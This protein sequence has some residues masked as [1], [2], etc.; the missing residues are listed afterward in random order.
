MNKLADELAQH[1]GEVMIENGGP[2]HELWAIAY[3]EILADVVI[4]APNVSNDEEKIVDKIKEINPKIMLVITK[5]NSSGKYLPLDLVDRAL[6]AKAN[7]LIE[8]DQDETSILASIVDPLGNRFLNASPDIKAVANRLH[9]RV[10]YLKSMTR[11]GCIHFHDI[12]E[13]K[14]TLADCKDFIN[15]AKDYADVFSDLIHTKNPSRFLGNA[16]FRCEAGFPSLRVKDGIYVTR[17]NCDKRDLVPE[18][19]VAVELNGNKVRYYGDHKPSVDT[20]IQRELYKLYPNIN[21]MIHSHVYVDRAPFTNEVVPCGAFEEVEEK[22]ID[23]KNHTFVPRE[24]FE[25]H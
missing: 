13:P 1:A 12:E 4:W 2:L 5:Q 21:Y 22:L 19:F 24:M 8:F 17:R 25:D 16:S 20:P 11:I 23:L 7:L 18:K 6:K 10:S 15:V 3:S 9:S 14:L